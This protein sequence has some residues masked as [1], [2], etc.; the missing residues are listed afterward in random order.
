MIELHLEPA[1]PHVGD[2]GRGRYVIVAAYP[3]GESAPLLSGSAG[4]DEA[5]Y[6]LTE[7]RAEVYNVCRVLNDEYV[8]GRAPFP[9]VVSAITVRE[10][11]TPPAAHASVMAAVAASRRASSSERQPALAH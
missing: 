10:S 6:K 7:A 8:A 3:T 4:R 5:G 1:E 2:I 11:A 9:Y